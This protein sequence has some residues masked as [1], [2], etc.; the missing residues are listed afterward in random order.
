MWEKIDS[1]PERPFG[2]STVRFSSDRLKVPGGWTLRTV[3]SEGHIAQMFI[4][5]YEYKW[6]LPKPEAS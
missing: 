3:S 6:E 5:D 4:P 2:E 1:E